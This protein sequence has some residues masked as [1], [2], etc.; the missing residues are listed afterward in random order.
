MSKSIECRPT[1]DEEPVTRQEAEDI[2]EL[3]NELDELDDLAETAREAERR[4]N[5]DAGDE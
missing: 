2:G 4:L 5:A 3:G 1:N